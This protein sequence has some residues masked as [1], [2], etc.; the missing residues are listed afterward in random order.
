[1]GGGIHDGTAWWDTPWENEKREG[2]IQMD[3]K[4]MNDNL[5]TLSKIEQQLHMY[6]PDQL[7]DVLRI[8]ITCAREATKEQ[9]QSIEG[10]HITRPENEAQ[11]GGERAKTTLECCPHCEMEGEIPEGKPAKCPNCGEVILPCST[12]CGLVDGHNNRF[13]CDWSKD[14]GCWRFPRERERERE[15]GGFCQCLSAQRANGRK[16]TKTCSGMSQRAI[17]A[18]SAKSE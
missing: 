17:C 14:T 5:K 10:N 16:H 2:E 8:A 1:M 12:C 18:R 6:N 4:A 7:R 15:R 13:I 11:G 9:M 3:K